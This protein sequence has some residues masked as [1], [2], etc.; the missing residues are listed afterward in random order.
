MPDILLIDAILPV[1]KFEGKGGWTY[2]ALPTIAQNPQNPFGWIQVKG[3]IDS[4]QLS[5]YKLMPMGNGHLFL[6]LKAE[7]RKQIKKQAG[8][9]VYIQLFLDESPLSIP[10]EFT[11]CLAL[12]SFA[13]KAFNKLDERQQE[14][15][16]NGLSAKNEDIQVERMAQTLKDLTNGLTKPSR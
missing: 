5:R 15:F 14:A 2:V 12:D 8:D 3:S 7:L 10:T 4:Y 9:T 6:P 11:E 13:E 16:V 1:Q